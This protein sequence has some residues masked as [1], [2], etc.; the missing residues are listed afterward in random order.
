MHDRPLDRLEAEATSKPRER[1]LDGALESGFEADFESGF[2]TYAA[3]LSGGALERLLV[4]RSGVTPRLVRDGIE[5]GIADARPMLALLAGDSPAG[6][7][8]AGRRILEVGAGMGVLSCYLARRGLE[9]VSLEPGGPGFEHN[10]RLAA[11]LRAHLG[12]EHDHLELPLEALDPARHGRF[13]LILSSNVLE[14]LDD[15]AGGLA[16]LAAVLAPG[17]TMLHVCPNYRVPFEPHYGLPLLPLVPA[18]TGR[19]LPRRIREDGTWRSLN[20]V[21][22]GRLRR[23]ARRLDAEVRFLPGAVRRAFG[24]LAGEPWFRRRHP[25]LAALAPWLAASGVAALLARLPPAW[26]S[27]MALEWRP[28]AGR[29]RG[30]EGD[31]APGDPV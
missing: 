20:F 23:L 14:H 6:R 18:W 4:E 30:R 2:E 27:P 29:E 5:G 19:L 22:A 11:L 9:V 28:R 26:A 3:E 31:Q 16:T 25:R 10:P 17:G 13:D 12:L 24:R 7:P 15:L 8:L 1:A 21:T